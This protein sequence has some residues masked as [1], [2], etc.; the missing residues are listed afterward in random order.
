MLPILSATLRCVV[1]PTLSTDALLPAG[2]A[3]GR[4]AGGDG[5]RGAGAFG[6]ISAARVAA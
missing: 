6:P 2:R 3:R 5:R 4:R 1:E